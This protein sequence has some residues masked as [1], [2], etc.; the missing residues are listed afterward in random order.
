MATSSGGPA[1]TPSL[2]SNMRSL[3]DCMVTMQRQQTELV[4]AVRRLAPSAVSG[5]DTQAIASVSEPSASGSRVSVATS[6]LASSS[7][8]NTTS[9]GTGEYVYYT[10]L[11]LPVLRRRIYNSLYM[12][13]MLPFGYISVPPITCKLSECMVMVL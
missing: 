5:V 6:V 2:E 9:S 3:V 4:E 11:V 1:P 10:L 7:S 12:C 8:T 13:G